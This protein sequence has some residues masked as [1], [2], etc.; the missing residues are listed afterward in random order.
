MK[1]NHQSVITKKKTKKKTVVLSL[2]A[3]VVAAKWIKY[4][5]RFQFYTFFVENHPEVVGNLNLYILISAIYICF[6]CIE[7]NLY[8]V[9]FFS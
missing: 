7:R 1:K 6:C 2:N 8:G 4:L 3:Y 5:L 9:F